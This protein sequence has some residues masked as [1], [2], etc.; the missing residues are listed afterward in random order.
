MIMPRNLTEFSLLISM[1]LNA[2]VG[3]CNGRQ[4]DIAHEIKHTLLFFAFN[5]SLFAK[6]HLFPS[7]NSLLTIWKSVFIFL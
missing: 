3:S 7:F 2:M 5:E 1:L 4:S 6:N